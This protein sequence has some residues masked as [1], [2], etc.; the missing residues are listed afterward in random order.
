MRFQFQNNRPTDSVARHIAFN[1]KSHS[2]LFVYESK[3]KT[4]EV[5]NFISRNLFDNEK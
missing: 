3:V 4:S 1:I 2:L 5:L